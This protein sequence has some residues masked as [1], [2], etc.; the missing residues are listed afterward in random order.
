MIVVIACGAA[1]VDHRAPAGR[2]Y[3]GVYHQ[4]CRRWALSVTDEAHLFIISS[5]YGLVPAS[6]EVDPYEQR[7][8]QPGAISAAEVRAQAARLGL[9]GPPVVFV[10]GRAYVQFLRAAGLNP[11][12]PFSGPHMGNG[13]QISLL[14]RCAGRFPTDAELALYTRRGPVAA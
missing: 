12:T 2:P 14:G 10:G 3:T 11:A 4:A 5:R 13:K 9:I 8:G 6:T 7:L 1:K